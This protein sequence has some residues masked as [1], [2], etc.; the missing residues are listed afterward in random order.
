M[1]RTLY[2]DSINYKIITL[3]VDDIKTYKITK[4]ILFPNNIRVFIF[5]KQI[6]NKTI[7]IKQAR[8]EIYR[9]VQINYILEYII[10]GCS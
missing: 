10:F 6:L 7:L 8:N 9:F 2:H 5:S 3:V 1:N 4:V